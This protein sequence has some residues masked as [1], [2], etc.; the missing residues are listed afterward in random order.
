MDPTTG[1]GFNSILGLLCWEL[2]G[3]AEYCWIVSIH[4]TQWNRD[5]FK[6]VFFCVCSMDLHYF[7][8][9][10]LDFINFFSPF[11]FAMKQNHIMLCL[12]CIIFKCDFSW[13]FFF[14]NSSIYWEYAMS[15]NVDDIVY[16]HCH[17]NG[18]NICL[19]L[20]LL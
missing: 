4:S 1:K 20:F 10:F 17:Q 9:K 13:I 8:N 12:W 16:L 11:F 6:S 18:T 2:M 3:F 19:K 7:V 14:F 15:V 5:C